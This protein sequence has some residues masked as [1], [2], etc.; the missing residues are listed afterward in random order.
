MMTARPQRL[1]LLLL[2][3]LFE[4]VRPGTFGPRRCLGTLL[5]QAMVPRGCSW[6]Q[7]ASTRSD[8]K[9]I[10]RR[11]L[12]GNATVSDNG[13]RRIDAGTRQSHPVRILVQSGHGLLIILASFGG[14]ASGPGAVL[15]RVQSAT[16][17][18]AT[19]NGRNGRPHPHGNPRQGTLCRD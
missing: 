2:L 5:L 1:L 3:L 9:E 10:F 13:S 17:A 16:T 6:G 15:T 14:G 7:L 19:A 4:A 18:A 12:S 11:G 8:R